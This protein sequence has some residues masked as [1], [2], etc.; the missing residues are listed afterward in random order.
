[1]KNRVAPEIEEAVVKMAIKY[2]AYG[3]VWVSNE[4]TKTGHFIGPGGVRCVL[5]RRE[6]ENFK[7]QLKS[8]EAMVAREGLILTEA[9]V[10]ALERAKQGKE[11]HSE[12]E[13]PSS[14]GSQDTFYVRN[15]K[16]VGR[17]YQQTFIDTYSRVA[18]VKL[19]DKENALVVA[20]ILKKTAGP[21]LRNGGRPAAQSSD[22]PRLG[23]LR[24][25]RKSRIPALHLNRRYRSH[26]I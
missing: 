3:Q 25:P 12:T 16:G 11:A 21:V 22:R 7:K 6:M 8:L 18:F 10:V 26:T 1:M 19:Y 9:Q 5:L 17:V 20:V 15:M 2:P 14:P 13:R 4:L 23:I 24:K